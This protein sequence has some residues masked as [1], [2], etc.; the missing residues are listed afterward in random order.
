MEPAGHAAPVDLSRSAPG[1]SPPVLSGPGPTALTTGLNSGLGVGLSLLP[2]LYAGRPGAEYGVSAAAAASSG[3]A[4]ECRLVEY[5]GERVAAFVQRSGELLLCL[6]QAR[7]PFRHT[8]G[9]GAFRAISLSD[10]MGDGRSSYG[11]HTS[12]RR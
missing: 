4:T 7:C 2:S 6:P 8:L 11:L 12:V 10:A 9:T 5:R 1:L 3:D